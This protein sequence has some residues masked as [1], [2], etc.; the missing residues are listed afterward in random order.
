MVHDAHPQ[1]VSTAHRSGL[2][3]ASEKIAIQHHRAHIASVLAERREW[4]KRVSAS[5]S[6]AR[7]MAMTARFGAAKF[8]PAACRGFDARRASAPRALAGGDAAAQ[9]PVQAAAGFLA[10][11]KDLPDLIAAP[12]RFPERYERCLELI[13]KA[14]ELSPLH[15]LGAFSTQPP[16]CSASRAK[17]VS[18]GRQRC[19]SSIWRAR[20]GRSRIRHIRF[21]FDGGELDF[22]PL[23]GASHA[24]ARAAVTVGNCAC[25]SAGNCWW[26]RRSRHSTLRLAPI[27]YGRSFGGSLPE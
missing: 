2:F 24:T 20:P 23:L 22:R 8:S 27:G 3:P 14:S 6:M 15:P 17:L 26:P 21:P 13:R 5:A 25:L 9:Y 7:A 10:Q 16:P 4:D 12:F 18:R 19:G 11:I 1:Y